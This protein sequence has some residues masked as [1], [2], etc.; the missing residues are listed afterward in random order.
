MMP[1]DMQKPGFGPTCFDHLARVVSALKD[2][3][4]VDKR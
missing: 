2:P 1:E 4:L 3:T